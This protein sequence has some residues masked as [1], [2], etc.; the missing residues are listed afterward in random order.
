MSFFPLVASASAFWALGSYTYDLKNKADVPVELATEDS[1]Q[2]DPS[3]G[4]IGHISSLSGSALLD[5][6]T[7]RSM[8]RNVDTNGADI[9]LVDY[10]NG[11][12][13]VQ[14]HDPRL[15]Q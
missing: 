2:K 3:Q 10:G 12:R 13:V 9:F 6:G 14:Y 11:Q 15:L 8:Q 1:Q 4:A 5:R 7:F